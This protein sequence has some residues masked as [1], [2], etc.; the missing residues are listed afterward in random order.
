[1]GRVID[2]LQSDEFEW[3]RNQIES[4]VIQVMGAYLEE[5]EQKCNNT[6]L[7]PTHTKNFYDSVW[8]TIE[9]NE[10]EI[11]ILDS[12][13]MQRL[14]NIKQL[15][16]ADVLYS[17]ATHTRFSHTLGV[18]QTADTMA[19]QITKELEKKEVH[20]KEEVRQVIRL[21]A[22][23]HDCGHM[24]CSHA[25][26][27]YF[28][29]NRKANLY[30]QVNS[31]REVFSCNLR[32]KPSLSEFISILI[33][34]STGIRRLLD[35]IK[36][37]LD[38]FDFVKYNQDDLIEKIICIILG[39]PYS[40]SYIPYAKVI[41]GQI[42][43]DKLDYLKRDS[44]STGVPVAVDMSRVF[45]KL[46]VVANQK[47]YDMVSHHDPEKTQ[48][49]KMAIAPAAINTID[50]LVMSRFMMFENIYYHQKTLTAE[51]ML[52]YA[53]Y[54]LD[55]STTG[56][57]DDLSK[58]LVLND[59]MVISQKFDVIIKNL[60]F[61]VKINDHDRYQ[62]ACDILSNLHK[63]AI[64][65]RCVAFTDRNLTKAI[66]KDKE[67]YTRII[68]EKV[69]EEKDEF[70]SNVI[71]EVKIIK[72]YLKN[73]HFYFN[74]NTDLLF[75][76]TPEISA[77]SMNSN[78]AIDD[79]INKDRD[80]EFEADSWLQSRASR[81]PQNFLVSYPEDRYI[82]YIAAEVVL[83]KKF[84][85]LIND[86]IIYSEEDEQHINE[87]KKYLDQKNYFKELYMLAPENSIDT[88]WGRIKDLI[89]AWKSYEIFDF[90]IGAGI[91]ID[92]TYLKMHLKQYMSFRNEIGDFE[93]FLNGYLKMLSNIQ[94]ISKAKITSALKNN[95]TKIITEESCNMSDLAVCNIGDLQDSSALVAYHVNIV[96]NV[97]GSKWKAKSLDR[98]LKDAVEGQKIVFLEDAFCSGRQI[99]SVFE[100]YMGIPI[101][102]RQTQETH[103][104]ELS[105]ELKQK[106]KRCK[107]Y[108]SFIYYEKSNEDFFYSR[109]R[110]IGLNNVKI[111]AQQTFPEGYFRQSRDESEQIEISVVKKYLLKVGK[112]LIEYKALDEKGNRKEKWT[113]ERIEQSLLGYNDAQ[114]LIAFSWNTP[115][116]TITPLW[117][118][119]DT[120]DFKWV[121]LFPR[122]DK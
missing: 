19:F 42:D 80:M 116:Y 48:V 103:V 31:I 111:F 38:N 24:F 20:T 49:Y 55:M 18:L 86:M 107:L 56:L 53:I 76:S 36:S 54:D 34:N 57:F 99:L 122:I 52:R 93:V 64:F 100:T 74:K 68:A 40:E 61:E 79:K 82:V 75:I 21:A 97:M 89:E 87:V 108:F 118:R 28:Q 27:M 8:G 39:F 106:L 69:V 41:S 104:E 30:K 17:S 46:R 102:E 84:G 23:F 67:F 96:N 59:S 110:E 85:L 91:K 109:L 45:Q 14:R 70:I 9:I 98:I 120:E 15:G 92:E 1:M 121:P 94:I 7:A 50:Q 63:R 33:L 60:G 58:V 71:E 13:I 35:I 101:D 44:H 77:A 112:K 72:G 3:I 83:L 88:L 95:F 37:G 66:Y 4:Y 73:S 51:E 65:K 16:L 113:D 2:L 117:L 11:L 22:I 26:E 81:K 115:T 43:S 10:G 29:K 114:Q 6:R 90:N 78:I 32:I 25:S 47:D 62:R 119:V 105:D 12:P 5:C